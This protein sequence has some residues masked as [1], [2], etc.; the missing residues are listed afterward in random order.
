MGGDLQIYDA[1]LLQEVSKRSLFFALCL[2]LVLSVL[3]RCPLVGAVAVLTAG[4]AVFGAEYFKHSLPRADLAMALCPV[5]AYFSADTYPSGHTTIGTSLALALVLICGPLLRPWMSVAAGIL[6]TSYATAVLFMGWHRP[7]D[8]LGGIAWSGLCFA[9]ATTF[10]VLVCGHHA[11]SGSS[12]IRLWV[13]ALFAMILIGCLWTFSLPRPGYTGSRWPFL[14]M[15]S[16]I[17]AAGFA[18][19]AWLACSLKNIAWRS[20]HRH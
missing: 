20:L 11:R 3:M 10:L 13:S 1:D 9:A 14:T 7:S 2:V 15:A 12:S 16:F 8:A 6:S 19:P 5:P 17:I 4:G 18:L